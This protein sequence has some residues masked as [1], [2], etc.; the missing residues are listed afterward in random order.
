MPRARRDMILEIGVAGMDAASID[1]V[2]TSRGNTV[3]SLDQGL[4]ESRR[5]AG[6]DQ[7][8]GSG[9]IQA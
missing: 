3:C 7:R 2:M 8:G 6:Q 1:A 9:P 4:L 5:P